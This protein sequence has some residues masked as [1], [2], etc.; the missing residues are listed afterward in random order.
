MR[1][2]PNG[3]PNNTDKLID[4]NGKPGLD[5]RVILD[6]GFLELV[7]YELNTNLPPKMAVK[8]Q[9]TAAMVTMVTVKIPS[10]A[11]ATLKKATPKIN[12]AE[13]GPSLPVNAVIMN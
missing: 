13:Y 9:D 8:Y 11:L 5:Q 12:E 6:G 7:R 3:N 1:I 2:S 4:N 10:Q